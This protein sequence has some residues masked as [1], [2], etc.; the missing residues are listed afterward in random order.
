VA[1][2]VKTKV[3]E[4]KRSQ[5]DIGIKKI[6][7]C[8]RRMWFLPVS[9]ETARQTLHAQQFLK[10]SLCKPQRNPPRPS[11]FERSTPN[12]IWQTDIF[13][14]GRGGGNAYLMGFMDDHSPYGVGLQVFCSHTAEHVL[15]V[16]CRAGRGPR[17]LA[18]RQCANS[19]ACSFFPFDVTTSTA[20]TPLEA[21]LPDLHDI[22]SAGT[23]V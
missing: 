19:V 18:W 21:Y 9:R 5:L 1:A 10:K 20:M 4:L 12:Q 3:V 16:H 17:Y 6:S 8:R 2:A 15:E 14:F 13:T 22:R 7:Q 11:F 23:A